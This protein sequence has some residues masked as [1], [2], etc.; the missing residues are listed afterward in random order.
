MNGFTAL[1]PLH[2]GCCASNTNTGHAD[3]HDRRSPEASVGRV[4]IVFR[5][6]AVPIST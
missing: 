6:H 5:V 3:Q 2:S 4:M 1:A